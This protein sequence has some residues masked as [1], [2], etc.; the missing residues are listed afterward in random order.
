L[1]QGVPPKEL[2]LVAVRDAA[3]GSAAVSPFDEA[4]EPVCIIVAVPKT[5]AGRVGSPF[6]V[7]ED[8]FDG[9]R[10]AVGIGVQDEN[11]GR[12]GRVDSGGD[13]SAATG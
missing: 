8:G 9:S 10:V 13:L 2:A 1:G 7:R 12:G 11:E 4:Q 6:E 3:P 5:A